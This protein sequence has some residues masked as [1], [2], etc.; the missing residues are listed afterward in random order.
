MSGVARRRLVAIGEDRVGAG[1]VAVRLS[2]A[3][4]R[5]DGRE[6]DRRRAPQ[7]LE[8]RVGIAEPSH[9]LGVPE[10]RVG[11]HE[12]DLAAEERAALRALE[13]MLR[14]AVIG[15]RAS[16][17]RAPSAPSRCARIVATCAR[18]LLGRQQI[19]DDRVDHRQQAVADAG[20]AIARMEQV[21]DAAVRRGS[22][23]SPRG[24]RRRSSQRWKSSRTP[25][26]SVSSG[27]AR[28]SCPTP[29]ERRGQ[30]RAASGG[31]A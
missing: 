11:V 3:R 9:R 19:G 16:K 10:V 21:V 26:A 13:V 15:G 22:T 18:R 24:C 27:A 5:D 30:G 25:A 23:R 29:A 31:G 7:R 28:V 8:A 14:S 6:G 20:L 1:I 17:S 12:P 2:R 4:R